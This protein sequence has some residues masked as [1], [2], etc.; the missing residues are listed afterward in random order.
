MSFPLRPTVA[1]IDLSA[2]RH[3]YLQAKRLSGKKTKI[4]AIVK[5]DAYG[6]GAVMISQELERLKV[7]YLG[8]ALLEE[9]LELRKGGVKTPIMILGGVYSGQADKII[10]HRFIPAIFDLSMARELNHAALK[11][12]TK[13]RVHIKIDTGMGRLG[14]LPEDSSRFF[15][16]IK[17]LPHLE[18]D[19]IFSHLSVASQENNQEAAFTREQLNSFYR[20]IDSC[21]EA[22]IH[23]PYLHL[24]NSAFIMKDNQDKFNLVRPGI[25]LYGS[26][27]CPIPDKTVQLKPVMR[28]KSRI[29]QL[30]KL[31][32][33]HSV[34]YGRTFICQRE[35]LVAVVPIGYADGY[36]PLLSNCGEVLIKGK[37]APV[38]GVVCM[39][40]TMVDVTDIPG[41]KAGNE[42]ILI[43]KQGG[44][45][46]SA[47]EVAERTGT[48]SYEVLCRIGQ[49]VP[50]LYLR[51]RRIVKPLI[52]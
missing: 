3:N 48:I 39:D 47:Q 42:V 46:I 26:Y 18:V 49:R 20:T 7:D 33:G 13:A 41:V 28:L 45:F 43:G 12:K 8:V 4:L 34:S 27:P 25:M 6:H 21:R 35:T 31:S 22:G 37:R 16:A 23:P 38:I 15:A 5:A 44:D 50:R 29:L 9:A 40:L 10:K 24:A 51:G 19:G 36:S 52:Q 14:I 32:K 2:L 1:E 11:Q 17:K 30:K